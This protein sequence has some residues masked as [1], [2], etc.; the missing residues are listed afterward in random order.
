M[1][2]IRVLPDQV[3]N[4]IAAG[5]QDRIEDGEQPACEEQGDP[6]VARWD[7]SGW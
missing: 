1:G 7:H 4:K 6:A 2:R 5:D 3:A